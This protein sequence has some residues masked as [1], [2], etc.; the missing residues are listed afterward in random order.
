M[1]RQGYLQLTLHLSLIEAGRVPGSV[2]SV[3]VCVWDSAADA[4][5]RAQADTLIQRAGGRVNKRYYQQQNKKH[6]T[7]TLCGG[8]SEKK[9]KN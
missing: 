5:T 4:G 6:Y 2:S 8:C 1:G 9:E 7:V 3:A